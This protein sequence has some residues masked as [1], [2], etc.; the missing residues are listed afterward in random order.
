MRCIFLKKFASLV[1]I[2]V[3]LAASC[4]CSCLDSHATDQ[5]LTASAANAGCAAQGNN[6]ACPDAD[7]TD[8]DHDASSCFCSCHLPLLALPLRL[9]HAPVTGKLSP[10]E[11]FTAIP[12]VY[13]PK[14]TPPQ[15]LA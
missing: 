4:L 13:L 1:L 8:A 11:T 15:N 12:E 6:P 2:V 3:I 14:F 10:L 7:H 9:H 5:S